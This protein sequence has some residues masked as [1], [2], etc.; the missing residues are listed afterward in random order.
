MNS[1][2]MQAGRERSSEV[3]R[4]LK[5]QLRQWETMQREPAEPICSG[6]PP[7]DRVLPEGGL[8]PGSLV[9]WIAELPGSGAATLALLAA[10]QASRRRAALV[11]VDDRRSFYPPAA[12]AEGVD[13]EQTIVLR[14]QGEADLHWALDQ[15]LRCREVAAVLAW[16]D[17][18]APHPF[19][20]LQLAAEAG[21][22]LGLL[23]RPAAARHEP[24]WADVRLLV[25]PARQEGP[26]RL[27]IE[28]LRARGGA[29]GKVVELNLQEH[30]PNS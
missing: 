2:A 12:A 18:L 10:R 4:R 17:A 3:V 29:G 14:P 13:L 28:L 5:Q 20:R 7:L 22:T 23:V 11:V 19:R 30:L 6:L 8:L 9:E 16:P 1:A 15:S 21:G 26:W 27:R 24:S 25:R